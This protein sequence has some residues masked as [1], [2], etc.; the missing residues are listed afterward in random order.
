MRAYNLDVVARSPERG[1][2]GGTLRTWHKFGG[3]DTSQTCKGKE[4]FKVATAGAGEVITWEVLKTG[5]C[6]IACFE[7]GFVYWYVGVIVTFTI[8]TGGTETVLIERLD[9]TTLNTLQWTL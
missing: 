8:L 1:M 7:A 2:G 9:K 4:E 3:T 5:L 6:T